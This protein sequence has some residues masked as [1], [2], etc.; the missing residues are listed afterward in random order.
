MS[1]REFPVGSAVLFYLSLLDDEIDQRAARLIAGLGGAPPDELDPTCVELTDAVIISCRSGRL[2]VIRGGACT[3]PCYWSRNADVL[4]I[5]TALPVRDGAALSRAG[6]VTATV[7]CGSGSYEP[8]AWLG[9]PLVGWMR[10]RRG[11]RTT[12]ADGSVHQDPVEFPLPASPG[13]EADR[14]AVSEAV[15]G[16]FEA[17]SR[18]QPATTAVLELS[19]GFDSTLAG[20]AAARAGSSL[21]GVSVEFP[22]YEFRFE[23]GVQQAT[24]SHLGIGRTVLDGTTMF[25][26]SPLAHPARFDEPTVFVTGMRHAETVASVAVGLHASRIYMGHGGDQLFSTNLAELEATTTP[27]SRSA[28]SRHAWPQVRRAVERGHSDAWRRR[29]TACFV[30]DARQD[31]VMKEHWGLAIRTPFTDLAVWR[32]ALR[33][34]AWN[35]ARGGAPDKTILAAALRGW[36]PVEVTGRRG[37]VAYDGVWLRAYARHADHIGATIERTAGLLS[38]AGMSP[39]WLIR[40]VEQLAAWKDVSDRE[41]LGAYALASWLLAWE[42]ERAADVSWG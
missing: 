14:Q 34:T 35:T 21:H 42:F 23:P 16:A 39:G 30:Y 3:V 8:N 18:V 2:T 25:P 29:T 31:I 13:T 12:F 4:H 22:Y 15:Q 27:P 33:W 38:Q 6:L 28:Y 9:T 1:V 20:A 24:A 40:R 41:V 5:T 36:L 32:A 26:Y 7:T 19:G 10:L 11:M 17:F 37:K